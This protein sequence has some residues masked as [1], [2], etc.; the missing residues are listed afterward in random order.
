MIIN[1]VRSHTHTH[2]LK[3][4]MCSNEFPWFATSSREVSVRP[5]GP[6]EPPQN[7]QSYDDRRRAAKVPQTAQTHSS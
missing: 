1:Q 6:D 5:S 3:S 7:S 4:E 2:T